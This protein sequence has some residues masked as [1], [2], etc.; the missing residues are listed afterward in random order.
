[1]RKKF[2]IMIGSLVAVLIVVLLITLIAY[3]YIQARSWGAKGQLS[4]TLTSDK[5]TMGINES[6]NV[7][8]TLTNTGSTDLRVIEP[9]GGYMFRVYY[10]NDTSVEWVGPSY[11]PPADPTDGSLITLK[12]NRSISLT[13]RISTWGWDLK[14]N[15]SYK[16]VGTYSSING[17]L[18]TL[19]HWQGELRSNELLFQVA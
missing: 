13:D 11:A 14:Q 5:T 16:A 9:N 8:Y 12:P 1:M 3:P 2:A 15:S 10:L 17:G 7:T 6:I 19:P 4:L 18:L